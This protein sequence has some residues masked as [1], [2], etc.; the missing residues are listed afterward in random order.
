MNLRGSVASLRGQCPKWSTGGLLE[1]PLTVVWELVTLI[2]EVFQERW[3][4]D[5]LGLWYFL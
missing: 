3:H 5:N 2:L 1:T 4:G